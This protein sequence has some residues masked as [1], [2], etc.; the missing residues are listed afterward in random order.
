MSDKGLMLMK[1]FAILSK[2]PRHYF[3]IF[4][5]PGTLQRK[6]GPLRKVTLVDS[7][8]HYDICCYRFMPYGGIIEREFICRRSFLIDYPTSGDYMLVSKDLESEEEPCNPKYPRGKVLVAG[9]IF[10]PSD[11]GGTKL[12]YILKSQLGGLIPIPLLYNYYTAF[13]TALVDDYEAL[14]MK[15]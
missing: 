8:P 5:V 14:S 7:K 6:K 15:E 1:T 13:I 10:R 2:P 11:N 12:T 9:A 3:R 4:K